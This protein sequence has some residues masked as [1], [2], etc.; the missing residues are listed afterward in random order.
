MKWKFVYNQVVQQ[1]SKNVYD[2]GNQISTQHMGDVN[3]RHLNNTHAGWVYQSIY[4]RY[5]LQVCCLPKN[6]IQQ[7]ISLAEYRFI[8][9]EK[10]K[11]ENV[12][13]VDLCEIVLDFV[14]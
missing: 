12:M 14:L 8:V 4:N 7:R 10:S 11:L 2:D 5:D 9:C 1:L 13:I 6:Y 3:R